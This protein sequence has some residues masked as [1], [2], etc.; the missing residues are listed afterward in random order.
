[1]FQSTVPILG[2]VPVRPSVR[3]LSRRG[4]VYQLRLPVPKDVQLRMG[5]SELRW[6]L[7]TKHK[8]TAEMRTWKAALI[9]EQLCYAVRIMPELTTDQIR[10]LI[11]NFFESLKASFEPPEQISGSELQHL[12]HEQEVLGGDAQLDWNDQLSTRNFDSAVSRQ[13][14]TLLSSQGEQLSD[15]PV[16]HKDML[17]QGIVR[18]HLEFQNYVRNQSDDPLAEFVPED[19]FF[20]G[21]L[22]SQMPTPETP[23]H[24][25][26]FPQTGL[27]G[28]VKALADAFIEKG[29]KFGYDEG[30]PWKSASIKRYTRLL[31][32]F[33][34]LVGPS[35]DIRQ[36]T[37]EHVKSIRDTLRARPR[38]T[39]STISV[40]NIQESHGEQ[41]VSSTTAR[42]D[43]GAILKFLRWCEQDGYIA[44]AP[45]NV[46]GIAKAKVPDSQKRRPFTTS[47]LNQLYS[48]PLFSG[49]KN[50]RQRHLPGKII[51]KDDQYWA[52]VLLLYTGARVSDIAALRIEDVTLD[53]AVPH[54]SIKMR[55]GDL[56]ELT[57][58]RQIPLHT[59][60]F[61]FG[62]LD[63]V[64]PRK[65]LS[66]Q[67]RLF[68]GLQTQQSLEQ[69]ISKVLNRYRRN[70]GLDDKR[71]TVHSLRH[72]MKDA[73]LDTGCP[74]EIRQKFLGHKVDTPHGN[75]GKGVG[76]EAMR[77][78]LH[79]TDLRISEETR[80]ILSRKPTSKKQ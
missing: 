54:L 4:E 58:E 42:N 56:K 10:T 5:R 27:G 45:V 46:E 17:L 47:E 15:L 62:F 14:E 20:R 78:W 39:P 19:T 79:D 57:S 6:S 30:R 18:A 53:G 26:H 55:E 49:C 37:I 74:D 38:D 2:T 43:F 51:V 21:A 68:I 9:F 73:L 48:S 12:T 35:S 71:A 34:E 50:K 22:A 40:F 16:T 70:I 11:R 7:G 61:D 44:S 13:A 25:P 1:V 32:W 67:K 36:V 80:G 65:K 31:P 64:E 72:G 75:Y 60:L 66:P 52:L 23:Q 77:K 69:N 59:D 29:I 76:L 28:E 63:F 41:R 24:K 33:Y 3:Y 8:R